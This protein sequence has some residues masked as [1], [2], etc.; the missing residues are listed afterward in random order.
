MTEAGSNPAD[1]HRLAMN[2]TSAAERNLFCRR[3]SCFRSICSGLS[4]HDVS[5]YSGGAG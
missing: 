2:G 1:S 4:S 3:T 5:R